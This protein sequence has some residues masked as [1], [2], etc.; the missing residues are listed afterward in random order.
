MPKD[1]KEIP[2]DIG[3][4]MVVQP[5]G[6]SAETAYAIDQFALSGGKVLAFVDPVAEAQRQGGNPMM[7]MAQGPPDLTEFDKLDEGVG[8]RVGHHKLV[9]DIARA[10]S[11][12]SS[13]AGRAPASPSTCS[14]SVWTA[15][16][17]T[18]AIRSPSASSA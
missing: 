14:G 16:T 7:M 18:S 1:V 8:R 11:A 3:V 17:S 4:L 2:S 5:E 10:R 9:G 13:A 15:A 6:L 12:S